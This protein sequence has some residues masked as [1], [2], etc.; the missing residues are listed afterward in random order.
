M[1]HTVTNTQDDRVII[2]GA[3]PVGLVLALKLVQGGVPVTLLEAMPRV[4][5]YTQMDRA[6]TNHPVTLEMYAALGL[7]D[8]LEAR[9]LIAPKFQY[10][11]RE[12]SEVIAEFDH[13]L[14]KDATP[15]PYVLQCERLKVCDEALKMVAEHELCDLRMGCP[16][17]SFEQDADFVEARFEQPDGSP[18]MV[19]GRYIVGAEGA[20]SI[21]RK[22]LGI[23]FEGFTYPDRTLNITTTYDFTKH[24]YSHRNYISDPGEWM[25][26]FHWAGP[27][28][29]WRVHF[30]TD[31]DDD[32]ERLLSRDN[33]QAMMQRF[34][35]NDTPYEILGA[36]LFTIHQ[37]IAAAFRKGRAILA[38]DSA[39][40]NSPIG[41]MGMNSGVHDAMNLGDKLLAIWRGEGDDDLLALYERQR[42]T[43][44]LEYIQAQTIRN[45]KLLTEAD[46]AV[47]RKNH[48]ELR[49][50][51]EDPKLAREFLLR[52]SMIQSLR[53]ANA[54]T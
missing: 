11:D 28:Q 41:G 25:N 16:F 46:P 53:Q 1:S 27:P 50:T 37:R 49:R 17:V 10:W 34:M 19:R 51:A 29:V 45:K 18:G 13:A 44:A 24:G 38:G 2:A 39:H 12:R 43:I 54:I 8:R 14:I 5:Y 4:D 7:Y 21:V 42:R 32:E 48:D 40:V 22:A 36:R 33:C 23:D 26:L 15:F 9:G 52:A 47:R 6:G 20:R 35:P 30:H 31:P 3:G